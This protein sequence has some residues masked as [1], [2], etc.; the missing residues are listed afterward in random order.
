[1]S[2]FQAMLAPHVGPP[3]NKGSADPNKADFNP[4]NSPRILRLERP[5]WT[6]ECPSLA[7]THGINQEFEFGNV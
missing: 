5:A 1:M 6:A 3:G 4:I 2:L 7:Q